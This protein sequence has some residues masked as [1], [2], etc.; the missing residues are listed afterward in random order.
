M[1]V[2]GLSQ[3]GKFLRSKDVDSMPQN[4]YET[5]KNVVDEDFT[6]L[7]AQY[8]NKA[9]VFWGEK[10]T[11]TS[12][13]SGKKIQSLIKQSQFYSYD[14]DHY[15]FLHFAKEICDIINSNNNKG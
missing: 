15:F 4:M 6:K 2:F 8:E 9:L 11:A 5:F 13:E 12:L 3:L 14:G 10:D 7:F 1:K